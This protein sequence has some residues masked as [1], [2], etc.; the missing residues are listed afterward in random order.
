MLPKITRD[1]ESRVF[2]MQLFSSKEF[3]L[4]MKRQKGTLTF[5]GETNE[6]ANVSFNTFMK[7]ILCTFEV[8]LRQTVKNTF[9]ENGEVLVVL[10]DDYF[11]NREPLR[12]SLSYANT[13]VV[14]HKMAMD[15]R[16][17]DKEFLFPS[18]GSRGRHAR[19]N[20]FALVNSIAYIIGQLM[21]TGEIACWLFRIKNFWDLLEF[22]LERY[23][24]CKEPSEHSA[25]KGT[26]IDLVLQILEKIPI[27]TMRLPKAFKTED[28]L[29]DPQPQLRNGTPS[30]K[31]LETIK[32][33]LP[34]CRNS[35][36]AKSPAMINIINSACRAEVIEHSL[37]CPMDIQVI[38]YKTPYLIETLVT[39]FCD[40]LHF[41]DINKMESYKDILSNDYGF[42]HEF[43]HAIK[44]L[45][46]LCQIS[47]GVN[48][49]DS[50]TLFKSSPFPET[51]I[52][53]N[54]NRPSTL[55]TIAERALRI[56]K[57][58]Y[59]NKVASLLAGLS[60]PIEYKKDQCPEFIARVVVKAT[61]ELVDILEKKKREK[62]AEEHEKGNKIEEHVVTTVLNDE[63][64]LELKKCLC[65]KGVVKNLSKIAESKCFPW[66]I[67][68]ACIGPL[69]ILSDVDL[70]SKREFKSLNCDGIISELE[71]ERGKRFAKINAKVPEEAN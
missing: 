49:S 2:L 30:L 14:E 69:K 6:D 51:C 22:L 18:E 13:D 39:S 41:L 36:I 1:R 32:K 67:R 3:Q 24:L 17:V 20:C 56:Q 70:R 34:I 64:E 52:D 25:H 55:L 61:S 38:A 7:K 63:I 35:C 59:P 21:Q 50:L 57:E 9:D 33:L 8:T 16:D 48:E 71:G 62:L 43:N 23:I 42:S 40:T 60:W 45:E 27:H 66:T 65:D 58:K 5:D 26:L 12:K 53:S 11:W 10:K 44:I 37:G 4:A 29:K 54:P 31:F 46:A 15:R 19:K 47:Q 68:E 28:H